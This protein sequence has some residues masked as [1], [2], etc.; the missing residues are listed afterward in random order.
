[1][2]QLNLIQLT[3]ARIAAWLDELQTT[4]VRDSVIAIFGTGPY[5]QYVSSLLQQNQFNRLYYFASNAK[6][7]ELND[8]PVMTI[9]EIAEL[10]PDLILAGSMAEPEKQ[11]KIVREAGISSVF[12]YLENAG[13]L[14]PEPRFD[15]FDAQWFSKIHHLHAGKTFYVIGNGP[16]LKDTPPELLTGGIKMAGN[17]II[18][19]EQFKPD[20]YFVLDELAVELWWPKV[21]TLNVPVVAPSH[22]YKLL[23]HENNVFYYPACYQTDS[24]VISPL[25]T[26]IPSGNTITSIMIYFATFMGAKNIVLLGLD[27]NYGAGLGKTHFSTNYYPPSVPKTDPDYAIEVARLQRNGISAAIARAQLLGIKV[28]D[29]TPVK[30]GLQVN[31][32]HF[33]ELVKLNG[34][35]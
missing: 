13:T 11:L 27:N 22:L 21:R 23:Q 9:G 33:D 6:I 7:T 32:I 29:A 12:R 17:G 8:L 10:K 14:C 31:K 18:V 4:L 5:A 1:M 15:P 35:L 24:A 3:R 26:G 34:N 28:V 25:F 16:S 30:N 2:Q 20:F 19:R